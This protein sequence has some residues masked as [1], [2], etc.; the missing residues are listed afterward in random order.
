MCKPKSNKKIKDETFFILQEFR[1]LP[2]TLRWLSNRR[3]RSK[4]EDDVPVMIDRRQRRKGGAPLAML[5]PRRFEPSGVCVTQGVFTCPVL[6]LHL[7]R[8]GRLPSGGHA[9]MRGVIE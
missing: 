8:Y 4:R 6:V 1:G 7:S 3:P 9:A 5:I 2:L